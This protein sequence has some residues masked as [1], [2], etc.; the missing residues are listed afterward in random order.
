MNYK[1]FKKI[2]KNLLKFTLAISITSVGWLID[3]LIR[4]G[5]KLNKWNSKLYTNTSESP[6]LRDSI[7]PNLPKDIGEITYIHREET[8]G[9]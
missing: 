7:H 3:V 4:V 8:K 9:I 2:I 6:I 5:H 1:K